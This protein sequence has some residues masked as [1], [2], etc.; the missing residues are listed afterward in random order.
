MFSPERIAAL[1]PFTQRANLGPRA[2]DRENEWAGPLLWDVL[3]AAGVVDASRPRNQVNVGV[4]V[5]GADGYVVLISLGE[6]SP[7]FGDRKIQVAD[8]LNG[9]PLPEHSLRL[10]VPD[11]LLGGRSVRDVV[12]IDVE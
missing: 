3:T 4:R 5:I 8:R 9:Q 6:I 7:N 2:G 10:I 1:T 12:R 11:D